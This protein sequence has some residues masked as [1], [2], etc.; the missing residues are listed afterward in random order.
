MNGLWPAIAKGEWLGC[1]VRY[2]LRGNIHIECQKSSLFENH[3]L[4]TCGMYNG[5]RFK[6]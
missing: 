6:S 3:S 4:Q 1:S 2:S 5:A